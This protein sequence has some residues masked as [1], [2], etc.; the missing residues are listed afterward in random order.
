MAEKSVFISY[1]RSTSSALARAVFQA[2]LQ[3]GCNVFLDV[4]SINA[5]EFERVIVREIETRPNFVLIVSPGS[6]ERFH[7]KNDWLRREFEHAQSSKRNIVPL[8]E[9]SV[10]LNEAAG[11]IPTGVEKLLALNAVRIP[12]DFF[13]PAIDKL[14]Q[15]F[16]VSAAPPEAK[17]VE[18]GVRNIVTAK[19]QRAISL[20]TPKREELEAEKL[21]ATAW[22]L[23]NPERISLYTRAIS[24]DPSSAEG[25]SL[26]A[27]ANYFEGDTN[28]AFADLSEAVRLKPQEPLYVNNLGVALFD[29]GK[30][31]EALHHF[32][33]AI[34]LRPQWSTA[35][36]NRA[37]ALQQ[38]NRVAESK[39]AKTTADRLF[40]SDDDV[41]LD[42][43]ETG[44]RT[45]GVARRDQ[46]IQT[47]QR[48]LLVLITII[49]AALFV[50]LRDP[51]EA[52][53]SALILILLTPVAFWL[54]NSLRKGKRLRGR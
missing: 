36:Y 41:K 6:L 49:L 52:V 11:S 29:L 48:K 5:G 32:E 50:F 28:A 43:E 34:A 3:R 45:G 42:F 40:M 2:L 21:L 25:Y 20:G 12:Y 44:L 39:Q 7:H 26:R 13:D 27:L 35:H 46:A 38:L 1:R 54:W 17:R 8:V 51:M 31:L 22:K 23:R 10:N 24:A 15:R 4:D 30:P 19:I 37:D 18:A 9:E 53:Y 47:G 16:L 33:K 14:C